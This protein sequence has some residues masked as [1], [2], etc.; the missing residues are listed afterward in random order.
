MVHTGSVESNG[1]VDPGITTAEVRRR[2]NLHGE[3][4]GDA[5][6]VEE[7]LEIRVV[8]GTERTSSA[9][10]VTMRTPG[11]DEELALGFL[12][13]EGV[14]PDPA[15][16]LAIEPCGRP[17]PETGLTNTIRVVL[18][19][20]APVDLERL[21][22][23]VYTSSSCGV[24][25]KTSIEAVMVAARA[26]QDGTRV[27]SSLVQRLPGELRARQTRFR[28]TGGSHAAAICDSSGR[29]L[30]LREDVGRHNAV[31]KVIGASFRSGLS[32]GAT[33]L[34]LSG[35]AGFELVQKAAVAS[36]PIVLAVGAPTSLSVTLARRL[37]LTLAGFVRDDSFV[38]YAD[39][40]GRIVEHRTP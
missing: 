38:V 40:P 24:C 32:A 14:I 9:I 6:I 26:L 35:R 22:R 1:M 25:G 8:H 15:V 2:H 16:V 11:E 28:S 17:D 4:S 31:D 34:V 39:E 3:A 29:I 21:R 27:E 10:S 7:P 36:I 33:F 12:F 30:L 23:N 37:N 20:R 19:P 13:S 5:L 18:D